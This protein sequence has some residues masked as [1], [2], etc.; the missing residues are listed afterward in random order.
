MRLR[1]VPGISIQDK[2]VLAV[3]P[4][5]A[6][7]DNPIYDRVVDQLAR[8]HF[9][10]RLTAIL[11]LVRDRFAEHVS[12]RNLRNPQLTDDGARLGPLPNARMTQ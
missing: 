6:F 7:R 1:N 11:R 10:L 3:V 2:S 5:D 12:G 9:F 8:V 4:L